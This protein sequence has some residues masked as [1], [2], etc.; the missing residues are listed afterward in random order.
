MIGEIGLDGSVGA[1]QVTNAEPGPGAAVTTLG[2]RGTT[3][4][5]TAFEGTEATPVAPL[6]AVTVNV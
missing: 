4:G 3:P 1:A 2:A 6:V 5:T